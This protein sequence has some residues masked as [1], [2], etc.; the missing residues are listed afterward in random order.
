VLAGVGDLYV[1]GSLPLTPSI[2]IAEG[3]LVF[4]EASGRAQLKNGRVYEPH[5][6]WEFRVEQGRIVEIK[7][8]I[9]TLHSQQVFLA[10]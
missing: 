4:A 9:D 1:G 5:S 7:E 6:A 10:P 3:A 8:F 2:V